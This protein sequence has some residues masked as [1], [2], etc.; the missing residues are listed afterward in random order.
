[1]GE[2]IY[3]RREGRGREKVELHH[4][5]LVSSQKNKGGGRGGKGDQSWWFSHLHPLL[6]EGKGGEGKSRRVET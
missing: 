6:L 4:L 3:L 1:M 2:V 5:S